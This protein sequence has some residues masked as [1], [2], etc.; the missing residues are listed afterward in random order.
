M[1]NTKFQF[2]I[3]FAL[4]SSLLS[5]SDVRAQS[6]FEELGKWVP[7]SANCLVMVQ[8]EEI[9]GSAIAKQEDWGKNRSNAF[10][11]GASFFPPTTQRLLIA[12]QID[13]EFMESVWLAGV[14]RNK[15]PAINIVDV[16]KRVQGNI[17]TI[18]NKSALLLPNQSFLVQIDDSTLVTMTP[19]DRQR[20]TRWVTD[21]LRGEINVSPYLEQAVKF[22]DQNAQVIVAFDL[23]GVIGE[24]AI[25]KRLKDSKVV[26]ESSVEMHAKTLASLTGLTLGV[27]VRDKITGS[28]KIDFKENPGSLLPV[29]KDIL[30][31][32]L[33]KNGLMIDDIGSWMVSAGPN[34][35]R[36]TGS[37]SSEGLRQIGSLIHQPLIDDFTGAGDE[38]SLGAQDPAANMATKSLQYFGDVQSV[39]EMIRRKDLGQLNSYS[40]WFDRYSRQLDAISILG[41]DPVMVDYGTYVANA[42]RDV[43]GGLNSSDLARTKSVQEQG[44]SG[45]G[46][47][48]FNYGYGYGTISSR[49]YTRNS[50]RAASEIATQAGANDAKDIMREIEAETAKVSRAM[51]EKYQIEFP[52]S[53]K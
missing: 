3:L 25:V 21:K 17:E 2:C 8:A 47:Q 23:G 9:F 40:K 36:L 27:T 7:S 20:T 6:N 39:L 52:I 37:L 38:G 19:A 35:I 16:S 32:A 18:A 30:I 46:S 11:S 15:G 28:I 33:K 24:S 44:F 14:F 4:C 45:P 48:T 34:E 42:F 43:S 31:A 13:F 5:F 41:V 26:S 49:Q 53:T 1:K 22:A 12:S 29:A 50:R 10:R 51:T